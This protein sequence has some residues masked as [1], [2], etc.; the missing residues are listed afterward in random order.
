MMAVKII[1][2]AALGFVI[3]AAICLIIIVLKQPADSHPLRE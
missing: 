1:A 2:C 3:I